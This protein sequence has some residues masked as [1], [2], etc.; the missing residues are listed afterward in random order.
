MTGHEVCK[1]GTV[2]IAPKQRAFFDFIRAHRELFPGFFLLDAETNIRPK[3]E[4]LQA[5][6]F[7][8]RPDRPLAADA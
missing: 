3:L 2:E 6:G 4:A 7:Y 8:V 1:V 5:H